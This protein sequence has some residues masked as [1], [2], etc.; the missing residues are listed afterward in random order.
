[1]K[2]RFIPPCTLLASALLLSGCDLLLGSADV[3]FTDRNCHAQIPDHPMSEEAEREIVA[4][5][6]EYK[7]R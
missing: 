6:Q 2:I 4:Y 3:P 5:C 7:R 1:M